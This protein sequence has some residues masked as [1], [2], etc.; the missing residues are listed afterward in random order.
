[1]T[2][3]F[4][5]DFRL[6]KQNRQTILIFMVLA[7]IMG[8]TQN[9]TF[10]M[11]YLPFCMA[12][13]VTS[14]IS[15]DEMDNGFQFLMTLPVSRNSYVNEKYFLCMGSAVISWLM[16]VVLYFISKVLHGNAIDFL[17]D[18]QT[19]MAFL[20]VI[21]ISLSVMIPV[22]LKFGVEKS[23]IVLICL[24]GSI[25]A[26]VYVATE[27]LDPD[28]IGILRWIGSINETVLLTTGIIFMVAAAVFSWMISRKMMMN[29]E[30]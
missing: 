8:L 11:G 1:M 26:A 20:P 29:K 15:Y 14:L 30:F 12:I 23:R 16:S 24:A 2:G 9:S 19:L 28:T 13:F 5:K 6:M 25:I 17:S 7:L 4:I 22:Q 27:V 3:L 21:I 10:I 18:I